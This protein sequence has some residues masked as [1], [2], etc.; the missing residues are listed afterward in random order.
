MLL[1]DIRVEILIDKIREGSSIRVR[2]QKLLGQGAARRKDTDA[3]T[4]RSPTCKRRRDVRID[5]RLQ[6]SVRVTLSP[7]L[8]LQRFQSGRLTIAR[9]EPFYIRVQRH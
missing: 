8:S 9:Y 6:R 4:P 3:Q 5:L 1:A 7:D 2:K